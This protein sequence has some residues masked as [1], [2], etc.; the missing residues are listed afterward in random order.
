MKTI[1]GKEKGNNIGIREFLKKIPRY[2]SHTINTNCELQ[3]RFRP[4][5]TKNIGNINF[6]FKSFC[7]WDV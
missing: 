1:P 5:V 4:T 6:F 7:Y 3:L 2:E